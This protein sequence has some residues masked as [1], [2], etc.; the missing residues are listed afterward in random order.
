MVQMTGSYTRASEQKYEEFLTKLGVGFMM[1]KAATVSTP[2]MEITES[3]GKWKM[4]TSTSMKSIVLEFELVFFFV[5]PLLNMICPRIF[6][7]CQKQ[8]KTK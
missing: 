7:F 8:S 4:V 2:K 6:I 3:G 5:F 1:R